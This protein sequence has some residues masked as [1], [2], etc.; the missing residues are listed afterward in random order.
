MAENDPTKCREPIRL[1]VH[2]RDR[3]FLKEVLAMARDGVRDDLSEHG[4]RLRRPSC[5]QRELAAYERL[6]AA[7]EGESLVPDP[8][9]RTVLADLARTVDSSNEYPRVIAEHEAMCGLLAALDQTRG[10]RSRRSTPCAAIRCRGDN[11]TSRR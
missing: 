4:D 2:R 11:P 8:D 5:Q 1:A 10:S 3:K 9:L 6:L 7:V